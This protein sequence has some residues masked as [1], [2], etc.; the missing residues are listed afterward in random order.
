MMIKNFRAIS[1]TFCM[2]L[3]ISACGK[4]TKTDFFG[5]EEKAVKPKVS[6]STSIER[7]WR[8]SIGER[9]GQ[10]DA[11]LSPALFGQ[12]VYAASIKG[13]VEKL[14]TQSGERVWRTKLSKVNITAGVGVGSGLVAVGSDDGVVIALNQE[15]GSV[16]WEAQ[17]DSEILASPVIDSDIVV[18]RSVDGKVYGLDTFDGSVLWT[19]SR[20]LPR[21]TLRGDSR[22]VITQGVV[23]AGFSDGNMAAVE[24]RSGRAL[25]DFPISFARGTNEI[26]RLADVDTD[27]LLVGQYLYVTSYRETT[28]ALNI[29]TQSIDWSAEVSSFSPMAYDAANL[30][31]SDRNGV[32]HQLDRRSGTTNWSQKGL[33]LFTT[34]APIS[35]G[36]HVLVSEGDG[37]LYVLRK[38]DGQLVGK[39]RLGA[40]TIIG[41]PV[42]EDGRVIFMDS[43]GGLQSISVVDRG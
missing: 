40:S 29:Q 4:T 24:A 41:Q 30:Y 38:S 22:P 9:I 13:R 16:A 36:A 6:T 8:R 42:Y 17:L 39:H 11:I 10:G 37:G 3:L 43:N 25:W 31:I 26:D 12:H 32:I 1:L 7:H 27:P 34:S 5:V 2:I 21:L 15:D 19:I 20:Q 23:F 18:A 14:T 35:L 28:H 33:R